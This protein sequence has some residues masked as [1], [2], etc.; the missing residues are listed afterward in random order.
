MSGE[1]GSWRRGCG[2]AM[3]R[4]AP[5][6]FWGG[7]PAQLGWE[8]PWGNPPHVV[9]GWL[10]A[11]SL[12]SLPLEILMGVGG[13]DGPTLPAEFTLS[14]LSSKAPVT[15]GPEL[16]DLRSPGLT[17]LLLLEEEATQREKGIC[18]RSTEHSFHYSREFLLMT[19]FSLHKSSA[20]LDSVALLPVSSGSSVP[21]CPV[22]GS[23][24]SH[25]VSVLCDPCPQC[26]KYQLPVTQAHCTQH[27]PSLGYSL[28]PVSMGP[29]FPWES[30]RLRRRTSGLTLPCWF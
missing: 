8:A 2:P 9:W 14:H 25:L 21:Q 16:R 19:P 28:R 17:Q 29:W 3:R 22:S 1:S 4:R 11:W 6:N 27:G 24:V 30:H 5:P 7:C 18:P 26:S 23:H 12:D 10:L 20:C 13:R 15:G